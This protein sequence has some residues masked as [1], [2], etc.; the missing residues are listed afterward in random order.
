MSPA[1]A[2]RSD[3]RIS[4]PVLPPPTAFL[5]D[6]PP[7]VEGPCVAEAPCMAAGTG[8]AGPEEAFQYYR[9]RYYDPKIG[10]FISED[11]IGQ[12]EDDN[13]YAYVEGD[14]VLLADPL[15]LQAVPANIDPIP[16]PP[17]SGCRWVPRVIEGGRLGAH[18]APA[19]SGSG[20][21]AVAAGIALV[22]LTPTTAGG[23]G[24]TWDDY[25][26]VC[27]PKAPETT[28]MA[29]HKKKRP[30]TE[31]K[32]EKGQRRKKRSRSHKGRNRPP[33]N[34]PPD[35]PGGPWPP[36]YDSDWW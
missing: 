28:C 24:D 10:R 27:P 6:S 12:G 11:P 18:A 4:P 2:A 33:R 14:P 35:W 8:M 26:L 15:G 16:I 19:A 36:P 5:P 25:V 32:H 22:L 31:G 3:P 30:S 17:G 13:L 29:E 34:P 20:F 9:A 21:G 23:T 7:N 1:G